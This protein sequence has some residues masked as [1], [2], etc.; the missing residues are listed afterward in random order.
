MSGEDVQVLV[1]GMQK[2]PAALIE[3]IAAAFVAQR[4]K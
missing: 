2:L 3:K 4:T 1:A